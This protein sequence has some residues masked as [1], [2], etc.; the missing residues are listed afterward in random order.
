MYT[1]N[2]QDKPPPRDFRADIIRML[3]EGTTPW[4]RPWEAGEFGRT[5][6]NPTTGKSYRGGNILSLMVASMRKGYTDPRFCTYK[7][8]AEKGWQV[9]KGEKGTQIE[10]WEAKPGS[11]EDD[12]ADDEKRNRLI[13]RVYTVFNAEQIDGIRPL[14]IEP[15][16]P[17]E[18][19]EA[20][21]TMLEELRRGH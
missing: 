19:I 6:F 10:F 9:R 3:E 18:A 2:S 17:F 5:P 13:H 4:Q 11:K 8:A 12:A 20:G 14:A 7:Q 15:R 1:R 16:K 21:E